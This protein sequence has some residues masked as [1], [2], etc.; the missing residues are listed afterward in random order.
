MKQVFLKIFIEHFQWLLLSIQK[1]K[2][3]YL[4]SEIT[5][6]LTSSQLREKCS[7]SEFFMAIIFR[8]L[9]WIRKYALWITVFSPNTVQ[10]Q[11][12]SRSVISENLLPIGCNESGMDN[13]CVHNLNCTIIRCSCSILDV[14]WTSCG[15]YFRSCTHWTFC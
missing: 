1:L 14:K 2:H 13:Q 15:V 10:K 3:N 4:I 12:L 9:D 8:Y 11:T 5:L 6:I 7:Y